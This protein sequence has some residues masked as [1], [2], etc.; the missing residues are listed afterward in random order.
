MNKISP[1]TSVVLDAIFRANSQS[2]NS[3]AAAIRAAIHQVM[4][5]V[6]D[7]SEPTGCSLLDNVNKLKAIHRKIIRLDILKVAR[8]LE[9]Y[10]DISTI[11]EELNI[12]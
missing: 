7:E 1:E 11:I 4:P 6:M 9:Y 12:V 5:E 2:K 3:H 10:D 8:E